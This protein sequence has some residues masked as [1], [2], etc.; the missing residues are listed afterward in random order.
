MLVSRTNLIVAAI[1]L[2]GLFAS[3]GVS[4]QAVDVN[5]LSVTIPTIKSGPPMDGTIS[6]P[7]WQ[8]AAKVHLSYDRQTHAAGAEDT[9]A[10]LLTDGVSLYVA[11]DAKQTRTPIVANQHSNNTG[12]DT[13]DE[14]KVA[15]WPGGPSGFN[16]QFIS[17]PLGTR[18]NIPRRICH[19]NQHGTRPARSHRT[20]GLLRCAFRF[21]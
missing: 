2:A 9:I 21:R 20:S 3:P 19:T 8:E 18:Y 4:A 14:V 1:T 16:Y 17:T 12:V 11:F 15:L 10:Y 7:V 6:S 5:G 13:D